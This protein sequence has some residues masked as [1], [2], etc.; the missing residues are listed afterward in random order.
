M[1]TL[2]AAAAIAALATLPAAAQPRAKEC[3]DKP[4]PAATEGVA[5]AIDGDTL[6]VP[7]MP[8]VRIWGIQA[9]E[10]RKKDTPGS[11]GIETT[12]GMIGRAVLEDELEVVGRRV[13]VEPTKWDRYCRIVAQ[14]WIWPKEMG[15]KIDLG[16]LLLTKGVAYG[17]MLDDTIAKRPNLGAQ[18]ATAEAGARKARS[19]L[20]KDW[21]GEK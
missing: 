6:A 17:F 13:F 4:L 3:A 9:A 15:D 12:A 18:Y 7:G 10:L 2:L 16:A 21:L 20:W 5:F 14:V 11:T 8:N 19:G 1:K